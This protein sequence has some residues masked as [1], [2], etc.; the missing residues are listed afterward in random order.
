ME[1]QSHSGPCQDPQGLQTCPHPREQG[2]AEEHL[3]IHSFLFLA[4]FWKLYLPALSLPT[5]PP[6]SPPPIPTIP[7]GWVRGLYWALPQA[8]CHLSIS[9]SGLS[10]PGMCLSL[11]DSMAFVVLLTVV[12]Q[13]L[14][15]GS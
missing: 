5:P 11:T 8:S 12:P 13:H 15:P 10:P 3:H 9:S 2:M 4:L 14:A 1:G 6:T 7:P